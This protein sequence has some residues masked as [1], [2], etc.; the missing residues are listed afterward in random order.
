MSSSPIFFSLSFDEIIVFLLPEGTE[1]K[2]VDSGALGHLDT[3]DP[4]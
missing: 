4:I 1:M 2:Q 3:R